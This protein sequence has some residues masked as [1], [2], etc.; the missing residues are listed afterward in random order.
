M[1]GVTLL[2]GGRTYTSVEAGSNGST[3]VD[4]MVSGEGSE[5]RTARAPDAKS[6]AICATAT[7][8][9]GMHGRA[10]PP[11]GKVEKMRKKEMN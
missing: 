11:H 7:L 9:G 4:A 2:K 8:V 10:M 3:P 1:M 5:C 6:A